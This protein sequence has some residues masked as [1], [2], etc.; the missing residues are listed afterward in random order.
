MKRNLLAISVL[1]FCAV[2]TAAQSPIPTPIPTPVRSVNE[3]RNMPRSTTEITDRDTLEDKEWERA[4]IPRA[5]FDIS[6][7]ARAKVKISKEEKALYEK[8]AADNN[9]KILKLFSA[10]QCAENRLVLN[11]RDERCAAAA[12]LLRVSFYSFLIGYYGETISDFRILEDTLIAGNGKYIH[13][14]LVDLGETEIGRIGKESAEVVFL[15]SYPAATTA[16]EE[17]RQRSDLEKGFSYQNLQI[18]SRQ[19]LRAD[20]VYLMRLVSYSSKDD[21]ASIYNKDS[22]YVFKVGGLNAD[23]MAVILWRKLFQKDAPRLKSDE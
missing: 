16:T 8:I 18:S 4:F 5:P 12:D 21:R 19:K 20:H 11:A 14:F 23:G 10:P 15:K 2:I 1:L 17:S 9:L 13:G 3:A 6:K 7:A 22:V